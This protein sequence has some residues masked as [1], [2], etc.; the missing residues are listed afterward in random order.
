MIETTGPTGLERRRFIRLLGA[1]GAT[2]AGGG[3][4]SGCSSPK[5]AAGRLGGGAIRI[6]YVTPAT[7]ALAGYGAAD[8][9]VIGAMRQFF[10]RNPIQ[11][12]GRSY[13][14]EIVD[15]DSQSN[16]DRAAD[17]AT[18]LIAN[19]GIQLMLVSAGAQTSG[20]VSDRCEAGGM[21]CLSTVTPWQPWFFGRAGRQDTAFRWT[22]HFF[23]GLD[24][25]EAVY[26]DMW[27]RV[28]TNHRCA[29]LWP[30]DADGRTWGDPTSGFPAAQAGRGY[31]FIETRPFATGSRNF[32]RLIDSMTA[33]DPDVLV[34]VPDSA[35]F[36]TFWKQ[37]GRM[38]FQPKI[39][40]IGRALAFPSGVEALGEPG[41]D[42]ATEVWWSPQHPFTSS[43]TG[44]TAQQ[45]ADAFTV[46]SGKQWIQP[47]GFAHALF[48]VAARAFQ[49]ANA[50]D[51]RA[52]L[53]AAISRMTIDTVV[54]PLD[55]TTGPVPNVTLTPLVGGQ[56][57][58]GSSS[59]FELT[60]V[61]NGRS[62]DIP[63]A[64]VV[65]PLGGVG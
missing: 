47:L 46:A 41:L 28:G 49:T 17:L 29:G 11:V 63:A 39:A 10:A 13:P 61:S 45:L 18:D 54:G 43:L 32:S 56:W 16:A 5:P 57:R 31:D 44:Q 2:A 20:P 25:V 8:R 65:R 60:I 27:D 26:A 12:G 36:S 1:M 15:R 38:G 3:L 52:G 19:G 40:T 53:A 6:G 30:D 7:G 48:E 42:L 64:G 50:I 62:P 35:D 14:V 33:A 51:D 37:A 24:D 4:T 22:Y 58:A 34:G 9:F 59:P 21:P 23:W 55:W